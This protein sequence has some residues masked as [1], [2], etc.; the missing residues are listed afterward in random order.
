MAKTK[1]VPL[2]SCVVTRERLPKEELIRVVRDN[3]GN[4]TIDRTGKVNGRG[5][6]LKLDLKVIKKAKLSKALD[7]R[8]LVEVPIDI[9]NDLEEIVKEEL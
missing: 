8:L 3:L 9:Y 6:Y 2:R 4:V 1:K 5:A 7:N